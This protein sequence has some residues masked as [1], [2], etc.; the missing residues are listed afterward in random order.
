MIYSLFIVVGVLG[1]LATC[2]VIIN[3]QYMRSATNLYLT[4]LAVADIFTLLT[5]SKY[6]AF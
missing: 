2:I 1:N 3:N 6:Y 5:L 4:N